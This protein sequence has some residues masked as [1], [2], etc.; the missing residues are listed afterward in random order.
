MALFGVILAVI[1]VILL[2]FSLLRFK[3]P[4][5]DFPASPH[6]NEDAED[7]SNGGEDDFQVLLA[8]LK[9]MLRLIGACVLALGVG[10]YVYFQIF[11]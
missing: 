5:L 4:R 2:G 9:S 7:E 8:S 11:T 10:V 3:P 1:G 6:E